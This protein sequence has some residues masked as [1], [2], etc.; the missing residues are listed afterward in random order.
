[1][2]RS[3]SGFTLAELLV[4]LAVT[5]VLAAL[6]MPSFRDMLL[7]RAVAQATDAFANDMRFTRSEAVKRSWRMGMCSLADG[8]TSACSKD[9]K[10]VNG[11]MVFVDNNSN[12][13]RDAGEDILRVQMAFSDIDS[14]RGAN[15]AND[16][17]RFAYNANG[18]GVLLNSTFTVHAAGARGTEL[19]RVITVSSQGRVSVR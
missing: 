3:H 4:V 14:F 16:L 15:P 17:A 13:T 12:G 10:W 8:S 7:R 9:A 1:M 11:W 6:A 5:A 2:Q 18:L 19:D